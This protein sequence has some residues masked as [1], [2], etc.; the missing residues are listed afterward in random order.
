VKKISK[1]KIVS[2]YAGALYSAAEEKQAVS[3]VLEDVK[4][5]ID[6]FRADETALKYLA[7][8]VWNLEAKQQALSEVAAKLKLNGETLNCLDIIASNNR[9]AELLPILDEFT[10]IWYRKNGIVEVEVQSVGALS[11]AQD[12]KL[13]DNLEK[14]LS[15][16]VVVNYQIRPEILGGLIV[17]FGSS[18]IDDSVRGKLNRLENIMKGGQ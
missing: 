13:V 17:K 14:M 6:V 7:N 2:T 8:P 1:A 4:R 12:R 15:R 16:K 9:F 18:M 10:H 5:L 11:P 3:R